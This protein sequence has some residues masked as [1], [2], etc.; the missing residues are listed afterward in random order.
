L[1]AIKVGWGTISRLRLPQ[2][3]TDPAPAWIPFL[4]GS[5]VGL[6]G[7]GV[8]G[9]LLVRRG[10][11]S[12]NPPPAAR[13]P[14]IAL[15]FTAPP[16]EW[17][18]PCLQLSE[19]SR[20]LLEEAWNDEAKHVGLEAGKAFKHKHGMPSWHLAVDQLVSLDL[21]A[22]PGKKL[23]LTLRGEALCASL[24]PGGVVRGDPGV[25]F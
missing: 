8:V 7:G 23:S 16:K 2:F 1:A 25:P 6:L 17:A 11:A 13:P 19:T 18:R 5:A 9:A 10:P 21:M 3:V 14:R 12:A 24:T 22:I 4:I 20:L 15:R